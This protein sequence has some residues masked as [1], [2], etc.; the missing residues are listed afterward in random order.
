MYL[1]EPLSKLVL[2]LPI[3]Q[4]VILMSKLH[5]CPEW[6]QINVGSVQ[7]AGRELHREQILRSTLKLSTCLCTF[8]V[9]F[10]VWLS[11]QGIIGSA[12]SEKPMEFLQNELTNWRIFQ[13][14]LCGV[15]TE[16]MSVF[17]VAK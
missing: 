16:G 14:L 7:N 2:T 5:H 17:C 1:G 6:C 11:K 13:R 4:I 9:I 12:I 10:V 3:L 8:H 15:W